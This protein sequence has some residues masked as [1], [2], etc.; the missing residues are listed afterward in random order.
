MMAAPKWSSLDCKL[1]TLCRLVLPDVSPGEKP[2][3]QGGLPHPAAAHHRHPQPG[4]S[5]SQARPE[6]STDQRSQIRDLHYGD[7]RSYQ[8]TLR[9][10]EI[11]TYNS[12]DQGEDFYKDKLFFVDS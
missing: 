9:R 4:Q 10:S 8:S 7:Q 6:T 12:G 3:G 5:L 2:H 11:R 1:L